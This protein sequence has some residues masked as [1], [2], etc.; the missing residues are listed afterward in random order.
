[1]SFMD[2]YNALKKKRLPGI[3]L[4]S[5]ST[6]GSPDKQTDNSLTG[7][8]FMDE[9]NKL[10]EQ[11]TTTSGGSTTHTSSSGRTHGG[12]GGKFGGQEENRSSQT[13]SAT[14]FM[15]EYKKLK[16][17][18]EIGRN[19]SE[20]K[21]LRDNSTDRSEKLKYQGLYNE[22]YVEYYSSLMA[23]TKMEGTNHSVL[24]EMNQ[25][26][27]LK[28]GKE[29][30]QRKAAVLKKMEE[31]GIST[32]DY[33]LF[34]DD[35]NFTVGTFFDWL[36]NSFLSGLAGAE[37]GIAKTADFI[38]GAPLRELG[39][40]NNPV[41]LLKEGLSDDY[42]GAK[43]NADLYA[44]RLGG[45]KGYEFA[46]AT[47]EGVGSAVPTALYTF[48]S[49]G[50][51]A[52]KTAAD[53]I[54]KAAYD[55][56]GLLTK[57]G[58][59]VESMMK[60]PQYW[61]SF[62]QEYGSDYEEAKAMGAS[63]TT[64]VLGATLSSLIN[65]GIEIGPDGMSGIQGLPDDIAKGGNKVLKW[66]ISS[67]EEG[68]E[69]GLQKF[70]NEIVARTMYKSDAEILNPKDYAMEMGIGTLSGAT[71]GGGQ[72][73]V[74]SIINSAK[75]ASQNRESAK[76]TENENKVVEKYAEELIAEREKNGKKLSNKEKAR[77]RDM[78][79]SMM[80]KGYISTDTI[81][82]VLGGEEYS[83]YEKL[84]AEYE[85]FKKL[86]ETESGKL[87]EKQRDRLAE[88]KE[89]NNANSYESALQ[90]AKEKLSQNVSGLVKNERLS[91]SYNER[92]RMKQRFTADLN[93]YSEKQRAVVKSAIDSGILNNTNKTHDFVD[94]I[95]KLS[96]D[97]GV[98][99]DFTNNQKLKESG[100]GIEGKTVD[101]YVTKDGITLN[102]NSHKALNYVVGHEITHVLEGTELY[103]QLQA[104]LTEYAKAKGDYKSRRAKI[105]ELYRN[106]KDADIDA[107]LTADMVGDY[108][109]SDPEFVRN[110]SVN[111]RNVFLRLYDEIKYLLKQATAGSDEARKLEKVKKLFEDAYRKGGK[112][113]TKVGIQYS[114]AEP[115]T[116]VNG[117]KFENA[118]LL[119]TDFFDGISPRNWGEK[120]RVAVEER[121]GKDPVIMPI[122][123]ENGNTTL[124]QFAGP[125]EKV[126]KDGGSPHSVLDELSFTSDNLSKLA[127]IHIDEV[128][129]VS[130]EN[131]PYHTSQNSHGW[132]DKNGWL[133]RNANV[134]NAKNGNIY[135]LTIDIGKTAD[136]RTILFATKGKIKKVG[137]TEVSSLKIKGSGSHSN[138]IESLSQTGGSV[139]TQNSYADSNP[140]NR[141]AAGE[142]VTDEMNENG[143]DRKSE[144]TFSLSRDSEYMDNAISMN[145]SM[146]LVDS[147][148]MEEAKGIRD[149][150]ATRMN[151]IKDKGLVGL[152]E[153]IE[154]NTF[155]ANSSYDGSEENTTVCPR[156]LASEAF[157]DAVSEYLGR[158]LTVEEQ[159][160]ISQDLQGRSLTPECI[161]CYVATDRK[162]YRAFLGEYISQRDSVLQKLS[163][164]P[165]ADVSRN[166]DLYKE[167]L[168]GRKDTNQMYKRFKMWVDAYK[169]GT[170][171]VD[172]SHLANINRLMGDINSEFGE[173]LKPQIVDAM[174]YAQSASWAKKRVNYVAY[175]GHILKWKQ[176]RIN[177]LNSHYGLRMYSFSDFHPAFVLEN[178]QMV[179]D[180]SVRGLKMLGYT[181]DTDFVEI[182]APSGMNIN[183]S[184]FGFESGGNVYENNIIGAEWGKAK[185][186]RDQYPNVG[187]TFVATNDTLVEWAL[188][189]DWIDVVIPYHLVRTGTEVAKAFGYTNYTGES[190]DT[191]KSDWKKGDKRSI[192]PT[193]HNN[194]LQSYLEALDKNNLNPRF[195]RFLDNPNYMKL[196]NE[197]RQSASDSK[198]VQPVFNEDAA[199]R[200]LA[201]LEANG[202]YQ[203]IGG[204]V[205]RMYEIAA[206]VAEDMTQQ[207][208]PT[209]N[210]LSFNNSDEGIS[211]LP[212][213]VYG[214]DIA[215]ETAPVRENGAVTD[216]A[217]VRETVQ[218]EPVSGSEATKNGLDTSEPNQ[219]SAARKAAEEN[220]ERA[221]EARELGVTTE[222][223]KLQEQVNRSG[224]GTATD[225]FG[226]RYHIQKKSNGTYVAIVEGEGSGF[227]QNSLNKEYGSFDEAYLSVW[228]YLYGEYGVGDDTNVSEASDGTKTQG[229]VSDGE[230]GPVSEAARRNAVSD[231]E[232]GPVRNDETIY[233]EEPIPTRGG[234]VDAKQQGGTSTSAVT[235]NTDGAY[236]P[237]EI[238]LGPTAGYQAAEIAPVR[239]DAQQ[240]AEAAPVRQDAPQQGEA[241]PTGTKA[242]TNHENP[243]EKQRKWV[244]TS[245]ES[246][247]VNRQILPDNLDQSVIH[248]QPISNETTL[249]NANAMMD[250]MGYDTAVSYFNS[251]FAN[252]K[253]SLDDIA[254]GERL[255]QE[256]V[257][258]K[259]FATAGELIQNVAILGTELGQKVQALS[260]IQRLTPEGQL[261]MLQKIVE[262]GKAKGDKAF[263]GV[264]ITPEM[265]E[266]IL[267]VYDKDGSYDPDK[268]NEAVDNVKQQIADQMGVSRLEKVDAWR[269]LSMLGN[270]KTHIRNIVS[271]IA[272]KATVSVKNAIA[273]TVE[274][275]APIGSR[276][277]TWKPSSEAVKAFARKTAEDMKDVISGDSK[278]SESASIK[279]KRAIFKNKILNKLYD[280]NSDW[281]SKED[282]WFSKSAFQNSL[283]EFLTANGIE[284]EADI[285]NNPEI[286]QKGISYAT[287][288]SQIATFR[289]YSW[290]A[291]K[292]NDIQRKNAA[293]DIVVGA[294]LPFKKTPINIAKTGLNYSPL[295]F[296]KTLTYDLS[297]V[298]KGKMEASTLIDHLAQNT[299]GTALTLI[300]YMLASIGILNGSGDDDK[301]AK[302]D[303]QLGK[304]SYSV[305]I[306]G[307]TFSLSWLS[308]V[309]MPLFVGAN[310][311]EQLTREQEWN[312]D[313]VIQT[314]AE[315][316]DPLSE[317]SFLS[318][319]DS[320]L[321]SYD[322]GVKKFA[323][324]GEAMLQSYAS[325][326]IPT[327]SSQL[328]ATLD[329]TKR[330]TKVAGDSG[331]EMF[332]RTIN[333]LKYKIPFLRETLEPSTD[334]WGNELKQSENIITRAVENFIAPYSRK[335]S[336]A[337]GIDE[338][339]K[340]LYGETGDNGIIPA[341]PDNYVN[342]KG[343]K[344]EMSASEY[345]AYKKTYGQ[346]ASTLMEDLFA[347]DTYKSATSEARAKMVKRV[348]DYARDEAKREYL[349]KEGV[350]YTNATKD[351]VEYY[352][353]DNIKGA[354]ENDMTVEEYEFYVDNPGKY[355]V[356]KAV[357]GYEA[358][359]TYSGD[360]YDIKSDEDKNGDSISG[361][362]KRKVLEYI[363]NLDADYG[364]KIILYKSE[365]PGDD[366]YNAEIVDYLNSRDDISYDDM[367]T[368][369]TE[370]GFRVLEDGTI[371][372]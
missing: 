329:D 336:I 366:R 209:R 36:G 125:K 361:S 250:R 281:L 72:I 1:M 267:D 56:G 291:N 263:E 345:T 97:L 322:S 296:A 331:F 360:L 258:R 259:D 101:G 239:Q 122:M 16:Q 126:K 309:A 82:K 117:T 348:Y 301:E 161:Y 57:A 186:L 242:Q 288:Q 202:Y 234:T 37:L 8:D 54:T 127:V 216:E 40:E 114:I 238:E 219:P 6:I 240:T 129:S 333:Q 135:N 96:A 190:S 45:G 94:F 208:A 142:V 273:R 11:S 179:T 312:G 61:I 181:K 98:P 241:V 220:L 334:I 353:E 74:Q 257:K 67:A 168:G 277:K 351:K 269:Y 116:D 245:T 70:V 230:I 344:Y 199:M 118:V 41:S 187:V 341:I 298:K 300:G 102:I 162:A 25:I 307:S 132:F 330:S 59:T 14:D 260:I 255:I 206:E 368:I 233:R 350:Q 223:D 112:N 151:A 261:K 339:I 30:K 42:E 262:R 293:T 3:G 174:K 46:G 90:A 169:N 28:N 235:Q 107:E 115:F 247:P 283:Q 286:V 213:N 12:G 159:I 280:I 324:I 249:G 147:D 60:N 100:F 325:Q 371:R 24:E 63:D 347:T 191:K 274:S 221:L 354:I 346:T 236:T 244:E 154:G 146:R 157:V 68:G 299:T 51:S 304:Q 272:M 65:S 292:I 278:V 279:E 71:I 310:A 128:V 226:R 5:V 145:D 356:S 184:T 133:H 321:S 203:P 188:A 215:L 93:R 211:P 17:Q 320:V 35:S 229:S 31:L 123:D 355:A 10:K 170:P 77:I 252:R 198:P 121:A 306:G 66:A 136:G 89:K 251:Q 120:L 316:L 152:P 150:I 194:D 372:W 225:A 338:E 73:A 62:S 22:K 358:Y 91:E 50:V 237:A 15:D 23:N 268:L 164:N 4:S 43:F 275:I 314:L 78:A 270:P 231:G 342:Y 367:V 305:N 265:E 232:I 143:L 289:Q 38:I 106:V 29:K 218:A 141:N 144:A 158:P 80:E 111:H 160:Y 370:L 323:G 13:M 253:V 103:A 83:A 95:A 363:N 9:Y 192:A 282:W 315:T 167:F 266:K 58:L 349:A 276:T 173:A 311:Y 317:M 140:D 52:A 131:S 139:N 326:F 171:M 99:F 104:A 137:Q 155:F 214:K 335:D 172:A 243:K 264:E 92:A 165:N 39:W 224:M 110:L 357:G 201:K 327:A 33:A 2:E 287:E 75:A 297:Q 294:I 319:L 88:L 365:Y 205:E 340:N 308:P 183:V 134:I 217:P 81:E 328:A 153:D 105:E 182:F 113:T 197:C 302:Y 180:A 21:A 53:L 32:K 19:L 84:Q 359:K 86:Y 148:V 256:A 55:A 7:S 119:D 352:K 228:E 185:A 318:S 49:G 130:E 284:T 20:I 337:T 156:S 26:A 175:N 163:D 87:S 166:G 364:E 222:Y 79:A 189:Q 248:Y 149:R 44:E 18:Q 246:E 69:E 290:L 343:G 200:A 204:S 85:E 195:E 177:K 108:L 124:L 27:K 138:H 47:L 193:E 207:I 178:M 313:V 369:L 76:L 254:L 295:G 271:N 362:R 34:S 48:M 210:S 196:V 64:A 285:K 109:F 332:D 176:D 212:G 227:V 303:Y